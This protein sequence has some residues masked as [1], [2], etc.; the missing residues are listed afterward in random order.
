MKRKIV[1]A[2]YYLLLRH[3]PRTDF[4]SIKWV[5]KL[6]SNVGYCLF[7]HYGGGNIEKEAYFGDGRGLYM[8]TGS[9]L[10]VNCQIQRPCHIGDYV[11]MG[12][13]VVIFTMNHK[14]DRTD[15]PIGAQGMTGKR[16]V[17]IGNDVWIGQRAMIMPGV[18][19]GDGSII[20]AGAVVT[21][22]VPPYSIVGGIPARVLKTRK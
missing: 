5:R 21:K 10:G 20:A 7:D 3:L 6:R 8:G 11:L 2:I 19:V 16:K 17:T 14:A 13:D 15:I 9:G 22:D 18:T 1:L 4:F 12:P